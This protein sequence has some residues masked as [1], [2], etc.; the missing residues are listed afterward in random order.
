MKYSTAPDDSAS[1][2]R[3][4]GRNA[5]GQ[6]SSPH[7]LE[8]DREALQKEVNQLKDELNRI[9]DSANFNGIK[10]LDGSLAKEQ[11]ATKIELGGNITGTK[12]AAT[13]GSSFKIQ[14]SMRRPILDT[15]P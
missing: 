8:V 10:L 15:I 6:W 14:Q 2:A 11:T 3:W 13:K 5:Q 7:G 12:S 1:L 4:T 9:A